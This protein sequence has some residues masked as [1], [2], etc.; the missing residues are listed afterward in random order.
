MK[1]KEK[2]AQEINI[3]IMQEASPFSLSEKVWSLVLG[4]PTSLWGV[5]ILSCN[6]IFSHWMI[7]QL[8]I[9]D[10]TLYIFIYRTK[11]LLVLLALK[12]FKETQNIY[13]TV[14][15][16]LKCIKL[17]EVLHLFYCKNVLK[18][19]VLCFLHHLLA[20]GNQ[21]SMSSSQSSSFVFCL[22]VLFF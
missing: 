12:Y 3:N 17:F 7:P 11:V 13:Y 5:W 16:L 15:S 6:S 10:A 20:V 14:I 18:T 19:E 8:Q 4:N 21:Y 9:D 2:I 22:D 1:Q